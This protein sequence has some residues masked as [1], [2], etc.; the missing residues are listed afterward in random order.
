MGRFDKH[1]S[2]VVL[3]LLCVSAVA[4]ASLAMVGATL[5]QVALF[6]ISSLLGC[7]AAITL[8]RRHARAMEAARIGE[9]AQR[10]ETLREKLLERTRML[11]ATN[12]DLE[13]RV[14]ELNILFSCSCALAGSLDQ[15]ELLRAFA[16][17]TRTL[18]NVDHFAIMVH[19]PRR[20]VL[21]AQQTMGFGAPESDPAGTSVAPDWAEQEVFA[22]RKPQLI[23]DLRREARPN[24]LKERTLLPGS[25]LLLP[26]M[27]GSRS[28]GVWLLHRHQPDS[29]S[30]DDSGIYRTVANQL[31]TALENASLY[32]MTRE[33]ATHDELTGLY[34][35]RVL[36]SRLEMEWERTQR[37]GTVMGLVM[38]DVDHFK[39]FNDE[40]GHLVGDQVL[41]HVASLLVGHS[42]KVDVVARFGGEEFCVVLPRTD[43]SEA[44]L[45]AD[46][47]RRAIETTP[48]QF[49]D[50]QYSVTVSLGAV[51]SQVQVTSFTHLL[52]LADQAL[53]RAK[54]EGRNRV[55]SVPLPQRHESDASELRTPPS[56]GPHVAY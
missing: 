32:Q 23:R 53:Y 44:F 24:L 51:S 29:F 35:R 47:L 13:V 42:R 36:D 31:A 26:L 39:S 38:L 5:G 52:E 22:R 10:E 34:N 30:F 37:F 40:Y 21:V 11:Q 50:R 55:I 28:I 12:G 7:A 8:L 27:V 4:S 16:Q 54:A 6:A 20:G 25:L 41:R 15:T 19:D 46:T 2:L 14:R 3:M 9:W 48:L 18:L 56:R 17:A 1:H 43:Q 45:V 49:Q 33:L